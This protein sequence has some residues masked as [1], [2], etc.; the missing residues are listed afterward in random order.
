MASKKNKTK[1]VEVEES[2][3]ITRIDTAENA[4]AA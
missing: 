3:A 4:N 1:K 2:V